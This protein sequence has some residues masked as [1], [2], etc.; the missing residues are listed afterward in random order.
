MLN[1][2]NGNLCFI[3]ATDSGDY[4]FECDYLNNTLTHDASSK[5]I[6]D[7]C[8][9][10]Y[11]SYLVAL[12][13]KWIGYFSGG[14]LNENYIDTGLSNVTKIK[15]NVDSDIYI[16]EQSSNTLYKFIN[17]NIIWSF[18]LPDFDKRYEGDIIIRES[19]ECIIYSN[20]DTIYTIRD[21]GNRATLINELSIGTTGSIRTLINSMSRP[22]YS[23][24]R[25][26]TLSGQE[27]DVSSS[28]S[29][30]S[31][32]SSISYSESSLSSYSSV[33]SSSSYIELW[34]SSSSSSSSSSLQG[35]YIYGYVVGGSDPGHYEFA[36][37]YNGR[38]VWSNGTSY[39]HYI[40][41]YGWIISQTLGDYDGRWAE[42]ESD[43]SQSDDICPPATWWDLIL[44]TEFII[45]PYGS[46]SSS[47]TSYFVNYSSS[48]ST[49]SSESSS[50]TSSSSSSSSS[51]C[52]Y[53]CE[54]CGCHMEESYP[55]EIHDMQGD[56]VEFNGDCTAVWT[57]ECTWSGT[58]NPGGGTVVL[59][60]ILGTWYI[61]CYT[62][63]PD[64]GVVLI[65]NDATSCDPRGY[66][67]MDV[68]ACLDTG[69]II[70]NECTDSQDAYGVVGTDLFS[71]SSQSS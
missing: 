31:S 1:K 51:S 66:Y 21:D 64:C 18:T 17:P 46:S 65:S 3:G 71:E 12:N 41:G 36:G 23:C 58:M 27:L 6:T 7:I 33:S 39:L 56:F 70:G 40:S 59:S 2:F 45:V 47:S 20:D 22:E 50:S 25:I 26:R 43:S 55:I 37:Y 16:L 52:P 11:N 30:S 13:D 24:M 19:D 28:W 4:I 63:N 61:Q 9:N 42:P 57:A 34:S 53:P 68:G 8:L 69:C 35:C 54:E 48:S 15:K 5:Y 44:L 10:N 60:R 14:I 29:S 67:R 62:A 49:D 38:T 32:S